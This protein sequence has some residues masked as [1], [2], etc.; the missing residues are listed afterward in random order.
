[1]NVTA[2]IKLSVSMAIFGSIGFFTIHTGVPAIELVFVRCICA[3]LFLGGIW[4]ATGGH[5]TEMWEKHEVIRTLICGVFI[6]L[7]WVFLFKA[8]EEM[9]ISIA[10]SIYNL[11]P[12]F[13]LILG[14]IFLKEKMTVQALLVT[15][16]CFIGSIF[17]IG[18]NNFLSFTDFMQSGFVWALLSAIFYAL[19]MLTSKT[20]KNFSAYALTFTQ[21]TVGIVMLFPFVDFTLFNGL[22]TTNWLYILGTGFIHTGFVYYLFFDSIRNLSTII[23]SVLVFVDP[24]VAILLDMVL[25]DFMPTLLQTVGILLIFGGISYTLYTPIQKTKQHLTEE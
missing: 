4:L 6:V 20:I 1:M 9:S 7:N 21:T 19:T 8:F 12:I 14:S 22:T 25:L 5:K 17:I 16:T 10:I 23:V 18:L 3:T 2:M 11:A 15:I 24:V 13:V